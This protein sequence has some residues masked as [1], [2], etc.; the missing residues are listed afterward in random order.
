MKRWMAA[1]LIMALLTPAAL[2]AEW[3]D[4]RSPSKPYAGLPEVNLEEKL[5][6]MMFYPNKEMAYTHNCRDLQVYLPRRDVKAGSGKLYLCTLEGEVARFEFTDEMHVRMRD[7]T[8]EELDSLLWDDGVCFEITLDRPLALKGAYFV[9]MEENCIVSE[10]G[11]V[12]NVTIGGT[13]AWAFE[14]NAEYGIENLTFR[15][16]AGSSSEEAASEESNS[17]E[18]EEAAEKEY[19]EVETPVAGTEIAFDLVLGGEA[20]MAAFYGLGD[21]VE[22]DTSAVTE[23]GPVVCRVLKDDPAWGIVF[24]DGEGNELWSETF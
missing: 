24:L 5:G 9:N 21:S 16:E 2:A 10:S 3:K 13:E 11:K 8:P 12:G 17:G 6:Y 22:F 23:S 19:E 4:G 20:K 15:R 14:T 7:M 1:M 18:S